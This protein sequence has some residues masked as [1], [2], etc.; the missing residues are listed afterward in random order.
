MATGD[1]I[2]PIAIAFSESRSCVGDLRRGYVVHEGCDHIFFVGFLGVGKT[3]V[4]RNLG[5]LFHRSYV[6]TD[7]L[8][9]RSSHVSVGDFFAERGE[10]AFRDAETAVLRGLA[11]KQSLLISCGG[12]IVERACNAELMHQMGVVVYLE[13]SLDDSLKQIVC[14]EK[15]PDLGTPYEAAELLE[16]RRPLYEE[17]ADYTVSVSGKTF[18]EVAYETGELLWEEGLL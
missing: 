16:R 14:P 8:V 10:D 17:C 1:R 9:E 2:R 11:S 18:E 6:D 13:G 4:A 7:R 5:K 12:G 3:T 15:R